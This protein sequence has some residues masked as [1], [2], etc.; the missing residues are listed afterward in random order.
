MERLKDVLEGRDTLW[1]NAKDTVREA[2]KYLCKNKIGAVLVK[3]NDD[4]VGVFS[5]RDLMYRVV[6]PGLNLDEVLVEEVMSRSPIT[7]HINDDITLA[8]ALMHINKVRHLL[9]VSGDG[10]VAGLL[11]IRDIM[12][13][14]LAAS[15]NI[16]H[17]LNDKYYERAY[18]AKWRVSSNR[19]IVETYHPES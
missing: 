17:E 16:I 12:D 8:K 19:V 1:V 3:M 10:D 9:V 18:A 2:V 4:A 13:H 11:S 6:N 15:A 14:D 7:I 5:E